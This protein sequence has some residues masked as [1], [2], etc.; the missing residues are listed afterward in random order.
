MEYNFS[1]K[2]FIMKV[3]LENI[4]D[5][6]PSLN[7]YTISSLKFMQITVKAIIRPVMQDMKAQ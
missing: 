3:K 2:R 1:K 4:I 7:E 5:T 6:K